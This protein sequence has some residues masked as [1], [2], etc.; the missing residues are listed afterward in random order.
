MHRGQQSLPQQIKSQCPLSYSDL[1]GRGQEGCADGCLKFKD[2]HCNYKRY[3]TAG[4]FGCGGKMFRQRIK[5]MSGFDHRHG[6]VMGKR[7]GLFLTA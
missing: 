3:V 5:L 4:V 1:V 2:A 7:F 6:T